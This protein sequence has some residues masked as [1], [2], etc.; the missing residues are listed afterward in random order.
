MTK[1]LALELDKEAK[2][3]AEM[4]SNPNRSRNVYKETYTVEKIYSMSDSCATVIYKRSKGKKM[5]A[6][7]Y[8]IKGMAPGWKY[9]IP[10][11]SHILGFRAFEMLKLK[12]E[13]DNYKYNFDEHKK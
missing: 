9:F 8:Y 13:I 2:R 10:T 5:L 1:K 3:I 7:F 12:A 11:D 6:F 4:Y